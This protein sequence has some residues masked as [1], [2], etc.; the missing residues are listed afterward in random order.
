MAAT[1]ST[2]PTTPPESAAEPWY[3]QTVWV[4]RDIKL[5][6]SVFALPF[7]LL[8]T[9]LAP[10]S[11]GRYP[12]WPT[13]GLIVLC[14]VL[15][16]TLAMTMNRWADAELDARNDRTSGRAIPAGK[17][18]PRFM[19]GA[20]ILCGLSF[21]VAAGGFWLLLDNPWPLLLSPVVLIWLAG[22]SFTKR[23]TWFC[24][25]ILGAALALSPIAAAVAVEP[26]Y[27][28][29]PDVY[30]LAAMV[31]CWVAGFDVIYAMQDVDVDQRDQLY[32]M[33]SRLGVNASLWI[34]R[35]LHTLSFAAIATLA[36]ISPLLGIAF[37]VGLPFVAGLLI[38]EHVL[39]AGSK[40]HRIPL[41]F[42][43][44]N[45]IISVLIGALGIIDIVRSL[46]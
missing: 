19:L 45:G 37:M 28:A 27:L 8:A 17:V 6:H 26:G 41:V 21:V 30:L 20:A 34:A 22:Y 39:I 36:F 38:L 24:H 12:G 10:A 33:P 15:A 35:V 31:L 2:S 23:F 18:S 13:V 11:V 1:S 7:A 4:A 25:V 32:S 44:V 29:Q 5:S 43:T 9:F 46:V 14:M 16:R 42:I 40:T 3:R